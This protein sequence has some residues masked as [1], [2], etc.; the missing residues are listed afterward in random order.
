MEQSLF[1]E[2][3]D[4]LRGMVPTEL[5]SAQLHVRRYGIKL[6]FGAETSPRE[7]YE[8]QLIGADAVD[9]ATVL[10]VE[11]GFHAEYPRLVDNEKVIAHLAG[12]EKRWRKIVGHEAVTGPFLGRPDVWRRISETWPDPDL[13]DPELAVELAA[14][15]TDYVAALEPVRRQR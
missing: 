13:G 8:A 6:W 11:I 15:L 2:V 4:A 1:E 14:R 3:G 7:H 12:N 9:D 10:A 5:G